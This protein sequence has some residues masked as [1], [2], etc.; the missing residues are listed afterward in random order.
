M[1]NERIMAVF[2]GVA[3]ALIAPEAQANQG[4]DHSAGHRSYWSPDHALRAVVI[5]LKPRGYG[6][7]ESVVKILSASGRPVAIRDYSSCGGGNGHTVVKSRWTRD[8]RFFVFSTESS[9]G[10]SPWHSPTHVYS[11]LRGKFF[12]LD[13]FVGAITTPT[14][15]LAPPAF[16]TTQTLAHGVVTVD[17]LQIEKKLHEA[18]EDGTF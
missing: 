6:E 12:A 3:L 1:Q 11:R 14:F 4:Y 13:G 8:S 5:Y 7:A 15:R 10:H 2:L 9:G 16:V 18:S 17:L